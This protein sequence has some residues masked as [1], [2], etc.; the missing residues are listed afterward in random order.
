MTFLVALVVGALRAPVVQTATRLE[1]GWTPTALG[2]F[3]A[4][5]VVVAAVVVAADWAAGGEAIDI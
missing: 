4:A 5:A 2:S 3:A 1:A